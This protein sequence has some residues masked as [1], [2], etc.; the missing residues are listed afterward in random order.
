MYDMPTDVLI[1]AVLCCSGERCIS[2]LREDP[3]VHDIRIGAAAAA[4]RRVPVL[5]I[6]VFT[7][8]YY[9]YMHALP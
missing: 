4:V 1:Y 8:L 2:A 3:S 9:I 6:G 7:S 5:G